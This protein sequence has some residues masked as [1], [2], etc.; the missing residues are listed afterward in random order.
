VA[1]IG[2]APHWLELALSVAHLSWRETIRGKRNPGS[3]ITTKHCGRS[4]F[5]LFRWSYF[6][7]QCG[8]SYY[9][10]LTSIWSLL[11]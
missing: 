10:Y 7:W 6:I 1:P 5:T 11:L 9:C 8:C 4:G 2:L 3:N